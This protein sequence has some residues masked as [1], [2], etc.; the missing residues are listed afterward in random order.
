MAESRRLATILALDVAG[1]SRAAERDDTAAALAVRQ[2]RA[3]IQEICAPFG[4]RIFNTAGDGFM[5]EFPSASSGV[6]AALTL[7]KDARS[8]PRPL[9]QIRIG[10][11]LG[12][13][14]VEENG[15]LLGHGVNVAARL[16]ALAE[17]GTAIVSDP[18][19]QQVRSA[20]ELPFQFQG[21]VRL[22]KMEQRIGVHVL[23]PAGFQGMGKIGRRRLARVALAL[24]A[25]AAAIAIVAISV[26]SVLGRPGG[27]TAKLD[28]TIAVLPFANASGD[29]AKDYIARGI[30]SELIET[31][32]QIDRL[33]VVG[34]GS[35]FSYRPDA[36]PRK[37]GAAL[38]VA[39]ILSGTVS[40][41]GGGVRISFELADARSGRTLLSRT[42]TAALTT[43]NIAAA[44]RYA[45]EQV[46]GALS[47]ALDI[48]GGRQLLG[49]GTHS[50]QAYDYYLQGRE[51]M[52]QAPAESENLFAKA[53]AADPKY[54]AAWGLLAIA[55][56]ARSWDR[57]TPAEGRAEQDAAYAMAKKAVTLD[58]NISTSQAVFANLSTTQHNWRA[59]E[60]ASLLALDLSVNELALG[61][62]QL[63]LLRSGRIAE[64]DALYR[65]LEQV[66]PHGGIGAS[67][68]NL[69]LALGRLGE[70]RAMVESPDAKQ[71][72][73]VRSQVIRLET[74]ID[75]GGPADEV[76]HALE[77]LARQPDRTL[78]E[79]AKAV[80]AVFGDKEKARRVLRAW[81]DG[82]GFETASKYELIPFLAAWYGDTELVLRVWRDDLPV[83]VVRM[84][85]VWG[86]A[87]AP[88]RSSPSFKTLMQ[89]MG[90]VD[91]WRTYGWAN[92]CRP[93][94]ATDFECG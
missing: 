69:W 18:V 11:H 48:R 37:V 90:L 55:H 74:L 30:A 31:L 54:G 85:E 51:V 59:A 70:V 65:A 45:A 73:N 2:L 83:N 26:W 8:G 40:Q 22:D 93:V 64:A 28:P 50:L 13:V 84:T 12:D 80:L 67:K 88:A 87:Y 32:S 6:H 4:G 91:Y 21:K 92:K 77:V 20:A 52:A 34:R 56:G 24:L 1:Y 5:V 35:S 60:T 25:C 36:D 3:V 41:E 61:Q 33:K 38:K 43:D 49:A 27:M 16:Q 58:P 10:L 75:L 76:R 78:S 82:P 23:D 42:Y 81:Y 9:P 44:Q 79:F 46:A 62:R 7:L 39:N 47:I 63:I 57:P 72:G 14:I 86:P 53:V 66:A 19:R 17:P 94:G 29:P 89:D 71:A 68:Y 15:D